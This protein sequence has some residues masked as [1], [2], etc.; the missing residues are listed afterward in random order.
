LAIK[1]CLFGIM[2]RYVQVVML[3]DLTQSA[4]AAQVPGACVPALAAGHQA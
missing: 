3:K 2:L 1:P 4:A